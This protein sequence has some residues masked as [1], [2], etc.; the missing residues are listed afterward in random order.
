MKQ[1]LLSTMFAV[2]CIASVSYA[3]ER[4]VSGKVTSADGTPISGVS[5][6]VVGTTK[7]TQT[8]ASG[9]F[10]LT[11]NPGATI[12]ASSIGYTAQRILVGNSSVLTI[13]LASED[14]E[15]EE[16]VVVGYGST[17]KE[18][19]TGS[20]KRIDA[21]NIEK[22]NVSNISQ[23]LTGEVA[24][25]QVTTASGQP[26]TAATI[27][28]RGYG[29]V[30]GNRDPL[31]VVDGVPF[32]GNLTSINNADIASVTVLKDAAATAIYGS[33]GANGVIIVTTKTG[34]GKESFIEADVNY[35][36]NMSLLPRYDVV[37]TPE[38]YVA[39][40]WEGLYNYARLLTSNGAPAYTTEAQY[41]NY[42]NQM[43][44]R[45]N[46]I[47]LRP[48]NNIWETSDVSQMIDPTT[49][50]FKSG[51]NRKW[52][53][54][55]WEDHAFQN[56]NRLDAN[57]KFGGSSE[58]SD[59]F[60]SFGYLSDNG[61]SVNSD[62]ERF[63]GRMN[64][65]QKVT[66][67]LNAG[68]NLNYARTQRNNNGQSS[69]SGSIFWFVDNMPSIYPLF[70]RDA[71][72]DK[73]PDNIFGGY[74]YDYGDSNGRRFGSLTNAISDA[75]Y[76]INR[77]IRNEISGRGY[78]NFNIMQGLTFENSLGMEYY[79]NVYTSR[80]NKFYGSA[81]SQGGSLYRQTTEL[82]NLNLLNLLR[83]K[84]SFDGGHNLEALVAHE[85]TDF[86][87]N[88]Q[89][90]SGYNLVDNDILEFNNVAV[91]DPVR[92]Y[93]NDYTLESFFGQVNYDFSRKY[94]L[95]GTI[96]RDGS[97]RFL[98][99]KWGTFG[100]VGAGWIVSNED[101]FSSNSTIPYLKLKASYGLLG[102]Q[103]GV[104]YYSGYDL[105]DVQNVNDQAATIFETKGNPDLTWE[106]SKMFQVGADFEIGKYV[107]ATVEYY[108]K[109][110]SDL[111]FN[112]RF[113]TSTGYALVKVNEGN[114][115]NQGLEFDV[116]GHIWKSDK[117]YL[118]ISVNGE[119]FT[120]KITKM[121]NDPT[122]GLPK[123][124]DVQS[125]YA[126]AQDK[127]IYDYYMREYTGVDPFD[128]ASTWKVFYTD[129]NGNGQFDSGEQI[130]SLSQFANVND[131]EIFEGTTKTYAQATQ[132]YVGK[133]S[134]PKLR[135]A[136][137][138]RAGYANFDLA[139][140]F[141][142]RLG[143]YAYDY[144]YAGLMGNGYVGS[145]NWHIDMFNRWQKEGD[146][147][148]VPRI[149]NNA[150]VDPNVTSLST[151]FLTKANY[152]GLNNVRLGYTFTQ[153]FVK[154]AGL[155]NLNVW[156]SGDNLFIASARKGFNPSASENGNTSTYTYSPLS[157]FSV[158]LR[159][160]F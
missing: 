95:S 99:N 91:S 27:R 104:G 89:T 119:T 70:K 25:L 38:E 80:G 47:G 116:T 2:A 105:Y 8:D 96:R 145:N 52:T 111:I 53:P 103:A 28:V 101:F 68:V 29:S 126:W 33:R 120:N 37:S 155:G 113:G 65:N 153:S 82:K 137:N 49:R 24:G 62:F 114:L 39:L 63:S 48:A 9:S 87:Q 79:N 121:P 112:K 107:S 21:A 14:T 134:L 12:E 154:N 93:T 51:I 6:A 45:S 159:A 140:Q 40:G 100:S 76:N 73:I 133:S 61:Y 90:M 15:L 17:T 13:V 108:V 3:Q 129:N 130:T 7:A 85:V 72:G 124:I 106:T 143:G 56:S 127:S 43:L 98:N 117:G 74:Q 5:I 86:S 22:K 146:I 16:V 55:N 44:F 122:T 41:I 83:Y 144:A 84:T 75:T 20:A 132:Y 128:G 156:V 150:G 77:H 36:V 19:F 23:A 115:R 11:V 60:T 97:S 32:S 160:K 31:Y 58:K 110:T 64:L 50:T 1:K 35:G 57:V 138:L 131:Q 109:N 54:E 78:L 66:P 157:T 46:G 26:G 149:S 139:A 158:G 136:F 4:Q 152:L 118:D 81:A 30:N 69:D 67:W 18:A 135:G 42:A 88:I 148:D 10:T 94:Y 151:R 34:R 125:P 147:T 71:N 102:D 123:E 59:Y 92:S 142:Y 141:V